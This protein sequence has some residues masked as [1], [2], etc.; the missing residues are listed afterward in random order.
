MLPLMINAGY[1]GND[2]NCR[3]KIT[4]FSAMLATSYQ[5]ELAK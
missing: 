4:Y 2:H 5:H 1:V 3:K